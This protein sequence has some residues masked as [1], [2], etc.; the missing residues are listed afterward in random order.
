MKARTTELWLSLASLVLALLGG[1]I[2][3]RKFLPPPYRVILQ[4]SS[5]GTA[6]NGRAMRSLHRADPLLGWVLRSDPMEY[7]HTLS[8]KNGIVQYD[9]IYSVQNG[10]RRTSLS[11]PG[12]HGSTGAKSTEGPVVIAAGCSFTFGH[13]LNDQDS[14]PWQLQESLPRY[15]VMNTADLGYGTDQALLAAERQVNLSPGRAAAVILGFGD[16]Q[17]E[18]NR[19]PQGW[20][21]FLYPFA[22]PLFAI[23]P[24]GVAVYRRQ[25]RIW[26]PPV[27]SD[28]VLFA[29]TMNI[30]ANRV[31][32]IVSHDGAQKLTAALIRTFAQRFQAAGARLAVVMLPYAGDQ[33]PQSHADRG[34]LI[35]NLRAAHIPTLTPDFPRL[36]NGQLDVQRFMVTPLDKHPN[37]EYNRLLVNQLAPFLRS[38]GIISE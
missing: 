10:Q 30:A 5:P 28:S 34:F 36:A 18:R 7:R 24:D 2:A 12:A 3:A 20:L 1:E 14:W 37:R 27:L 31:Y 32:G 22:K 17:I 6:D 21:V 19:A 8:D 15:R 29:H 33:D 25:V 38:S 35:E 9:V 26:S 13:A 23:G 4:P 16:F 11:A